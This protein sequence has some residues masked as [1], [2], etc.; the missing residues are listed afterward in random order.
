MTEGD[1]AKHSEDAG[2][3]ISCENESKYLIGMSTNPGMPSS[4]QQPEAMRE[5]WN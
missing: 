2:E 5:V 1:L 4:Q 3:K